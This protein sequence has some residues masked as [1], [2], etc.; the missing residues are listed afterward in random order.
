MYIEEAAK[1]VFVLS[2]VAVL[3]NVTCI[4]SSKLFVS[5]FSGEFLGKGLSRDPSP[6][7]SWVMT[8]ELL[9]DLRGLLR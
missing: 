2:G 3:L 7:T 1:I 5:Y 6:K 4:E 9:L 8:F